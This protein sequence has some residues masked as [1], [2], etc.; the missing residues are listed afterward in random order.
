MCGL[1]MC[2]VCGVSHSM[3]GLQVMNTMQYSIPTHTPHPCL[4]R[5][6]VSTHNTATNSWMCVRTLDE[7]KSVLNS[8]W[9]IW[10]SGE[11]TRADL[12]QALDAPLLAR[13]VILHEFRS[14]LCDRLLPCHVHGAAQ[15]QRHHH[16]NYLHQTN[17]DPHSS[18]SIHMGQ[19][20]TKNFGKAPSEVGGSATN[21]TGLVG[22]RTRTAWGREGLV[23]LVEGCGQPVTRGLHTTTLKLHSINSK[24]I[25]MKFEPYMPSLQT[26]FY[27]VFGSF[28]VLHQSRCCHATVYE[29]VIELWRQYVLM[30]DW[31]VY[32]VAT[33]WRAIVINW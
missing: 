2:Y 1:C 28:S 33:P 24:K 15:P 32:Q 9:H 31:Y 30:N 26:R 23:V 13:L 22:G 20:H 10:L 3:P 5:S 14:W 8:S 29:K 21:L 12:R 4:S 18:K 16:N 19:C 11:D 17:D 6:C 27:N 7:C 25:V